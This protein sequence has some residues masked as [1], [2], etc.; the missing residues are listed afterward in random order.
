MSINR[1]ILEEETLSDGYFEDNDASRADLSSVIA[2]DGSSEDS[3]DSESLR[4]EIDLEIVE[5]SCDSLSASE[6]SEY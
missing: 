2:Q 6:A 3:F 5:N 1:E 4:S